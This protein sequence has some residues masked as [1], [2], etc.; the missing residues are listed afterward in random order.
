MQ[1]A[2]PPVTSSAEEVR[3]KRHDTWSMLRWIPTHDTPALER[4]Q[5]N[6]STQNLFITPHAWARASLIKKLD[7]LISFSKSSF[8]NAIWREII[9]FFYFHKSH[10][11]TRLHI[12]LIF[13][14]VIIEEIITTVL[15]T[16]I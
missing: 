9:V 4:V 2:V 14:T 13:K 8:V 10:V 1:Y 15:D 11:R 6:M 7:I 12:I 3:I 5:H 16:I